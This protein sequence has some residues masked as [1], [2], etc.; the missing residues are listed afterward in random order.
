MRRSPGNVLSFLA[1]AAAGQDTASTFERVTFVAR[2]E[3]SCLRVRRSSGD[4]A[5]FPLLDTGAPPLALEAGDELLALLG[6]GTGDGVVLGRIGAPR[7]TA[8]PAHL[9][10]EAT[11]SV[12]LKTGSAA[13]DLRA[14]GKVV[15]RGDDVLVRAKGT[16]RIRAGAV[17]IN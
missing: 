4:E 11:E 6:P 5:R 16:K 10:L 2:E 17:S 7:A 1:S 14:D 3:S 12:T 9:Q 13:V 8:V 15:I